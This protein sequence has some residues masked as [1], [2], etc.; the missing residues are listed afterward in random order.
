M[1]SREKEVAS[2]VNEA[3]RL[4]LLCA[5]DRDAINDVI[6]DYYTSR[7][8]DDSDNDD[9]ESDVE[10]D[11]TDFEPTIAIDGNADV[12]IADVNNALHVHDQVH[13]QSD[14]DS[15]I[16]IVVTAPLTYFAM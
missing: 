1:T 7:N 13:T 9:S 16:D 3:R 4:H 14:S 12:N 15:D 6:M 5:G 8:A 10:E 2:C 11:G